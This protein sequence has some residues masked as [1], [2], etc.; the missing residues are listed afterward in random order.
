MKAECLHGF[1]VGIRMRVGLGLELRH[2]LTLDRARTLTLTLAQP[3]HLASPTSIPHGR[4]LPPKI[5]TKSTAFSRAVL[6]RR[7]AAIAEKKTGREEDLGDIKITCSSLHHNLDITSVLWFICYIVLRYFIV[8]LFGQRGRL[9]K[10]LAEEW[11]DFSQRHVLSHS[12]PNQPKKI[13]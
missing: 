1:R 5:K 4:P 6:D 11:S 13:A 3:S 10:S 7:L 12:K 8:F 9:K 2:V